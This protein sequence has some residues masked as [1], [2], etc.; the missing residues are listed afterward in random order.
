MGIRWA[1][2]AALAL[3]TGWTSAQAA[4]SVDEGARGEAGR[5]ELAARVTRAFEGLKAVQP[6]KV[7]ARERAFALDFRVVEGNGLRVLSAGG[8]EEEARRVAQAMA[9]ARV[10]FNEL[11]GTTVGYPGGV[12]AYLLGTKAA[13]DAFL[14]KHPTLGPE[15]SARLAKLEGA[16]VPGTADWAWWEGDGERRL[17]GMA[18]FSFDWLFRA[19]GVTTEGHAWLHEGLGFYLTHALVGTR[20]TWFVRPAVGG[21]RNAALNSSLKARM[22]EPGA[23]WMELARGLFAPEQTFDLEELLH[24]EPREL[25]AVDY[26]RVH[27]LAGYLVEVHAAALGSLLARVGAG[28]DPRV[29]LEEV[30]GLSLAELRTRLDAWLAQREELVAR[31]AGKRSEAELRARWSGLDPPRRAEA[32]AAL[33]R[34][35]GELDTLQLRWLRS[36]LAGPTPAAAEPLVFFDPKTHTPQNVIARKRLPEAHAEV[37]RVLAAARPVGDPRAPRLAYDYDWRLGAV[38]RTGDPDEPEA[39]F[40]NALAGVP[41]DADLARA[42]VL[43]V[44]DRADER[45]IQAAFAH[46]YT[47]RDGGVYPVTLFDMWATG[48]TMEMPDVDTLGIVHDVLGDWNRWVAPVPPAQHGALYKVIGDLF[49][50]CRRSRELRLTLAELFLAPSTVLRPGYETQTLNLQAL[51]AGLESDPLRLA[52]ELPDGKTWEAFL[53]ALVQR[54]FADPKYYAA[55]RRRAAQLRHDADALRIALGEALVEAEAFVPPPPPPEEPTK[56]KKK[57]KK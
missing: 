14:G 35:L 30:V 43:A 10:L 39:V 25:E 32:V 53:P 21:P 1:W 40:A 57:K 45:A 38:V 4:A 55:G 42:R 5:A 28:E 24:L 15:V 41:P 48:K 19:L 44:L 11:T 7:E 33:R 16:G 26:V 23:D 37:Q 12:S 8:E 22:E 20:L 18:R 34:R 52:A 9:A 47:D 2:G 3:V 46:A 50:T 56:D 54:C 17:D 29:V 6:G 31:A 49:K 51:W 27:A 36:V 13:K